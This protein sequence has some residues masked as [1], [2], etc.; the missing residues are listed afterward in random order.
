MASALIS[1]LHGRALRTIC[2]ASGEHYQGL[3]AAARR[4]RKLGLIN[5]R[6]AK[7]LLLIDHAYTLGRHITSVSSANFMEELHTALE[8]NCHLEDSTSSRHSASSDAES[9]TR[10]SCSTFCSSLSPSSAPRVVDLLAT[11]EAT[12]FDIFDDD[13]QCEQELQPIELQQNAVVLPAASTFELLQFATDTFNLRLDSM[14]AALTARLNMISTDLSIQTSYYPDSISH[15]ASDTVEDCI[16]GDENL[17]KD[18]LESSWRALS[19]IQD[20][21]SAAT[22]LSSINALIEPMFHTDLTSIDEDWDNVA[23]PDFLAT[24][25]PHTMA[26]VESAEDPPA[27]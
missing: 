21:D 24:H 5:N 9:S 4:S 17:T 27:A 20:L 6:I 26:R 10:A 8:K 14:A 25:M 18:L 7:K 1:S 16:H 2:S 12:R 3:A 19:A 11:S 22:F 23:N 15:Q 13:D